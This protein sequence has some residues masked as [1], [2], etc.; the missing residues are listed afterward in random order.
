MKK[1]LIILPL[2]LFTVLFIS[3]SRNI[4]KIEA[5]K[6]C[7]KNFNAGNVIDANNFQFLPAADLL[8]SNADSIKP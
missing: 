7:I 1:K 5:Y 4:V 8:Q 6:P 2:I 3:C